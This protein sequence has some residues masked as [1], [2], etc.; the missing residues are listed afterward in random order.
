MATEF[1]S[2]SEAPDPNSCPRDRD[3]LQQLLRRLLAHRHSRSDVFSTLTIIGFG[4]QRL[5]ML[6]D[7][8]SR[9]EHSLLG[10]ELPSRFFAIGI[11]AASVVA[12]PPSR[13]HRSA[14]LA[15]AV[16]RDGDIV[17]LLGS[18]QD[19]IETHHPQG[20]LVDAC[21][22]S[23]GLA[24]SPC[25]AS[26]LEFPIALWLDRIMI[27]ILNTTE[28]G[29]VSWADAV[30]LCPVPS[31]W[32]SLDPIDLGTT[33]G[34]TTPSWAALRAGT[35]QGTR[36]P[37]G[38]RPSWAAWMDD[39]MFARWCM[40]SFPDI[41]SLR[42]DVEF[43]ASDSVAGHLDAALRAAWLAFGDQP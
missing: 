22:R 26:P 5:E 25:G 20:W 21:L 18:D 16:S 27:A 10:F 13:G 15:L 12:T 3:D 42:A 4:H 35:A 9:P 24:T 11:I 32:R 2:H 33:L 7:C 14:A 28:T 1:S 29:P 40:G 30:D 23:L 17:S 8:E 36:A 41:A 37:V 38:V 43:L 31:A 34:S 6:A 19:V 39:A